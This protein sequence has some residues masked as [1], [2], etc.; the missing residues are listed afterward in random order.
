[1]YTNFLG[2][3]DTANFIVVH[4][5]G[6]LDTGGNR[7]WNSFGLGSGVDD[8]GFLSALIDTIMAHYSINENRIYSTGMSNGGFM[9]YELACTLSH[10]IAAIASVTGSMTVLQESAC[11]AMHPT[12][13]MQIHGTADGTV[14]YAG[15]AGLLGIEDLVQNWVDFNNCSG[16]PVVIEV[17]DITPLDNCTAE[18]SVYSGGDAGSTVEFF[19]IIGGDHSWPGAPININTTNMDIS[20]SKE[21]WRFFSQYQLDELTGVSEDAIAES[22]PVN[23][24]PNPSQDYF[25][26]GFPDN[27]KKEIIVTNTMGQVIHREQ[28]SCTNLRL[29]IG[30]NGI[31]LVSI[32]EKN[33]IRTEKV[34]KN[35]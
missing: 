31:Y 28:C 23:I 13:V 15:S 18:H 20:A 22:S 19:K 16:T 34:V 17:P 7:F 12:P 32:F 9:S 1:M 30:Q 6:S 35:G 29:N 26:L 11:N 5:D 27:S 21:I 3:A 2:I 33:K 24:Y 10:R 8:T 14:A 4:P 25:N